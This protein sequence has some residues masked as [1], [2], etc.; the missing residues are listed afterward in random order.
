MTFNHFV[1]RLHLYLALF[2][3][4]WFFVY[5]V[6]SWVFSHSKWF[7]HFYEDG[8]PMWTVRFEKPYQIDIPK[9]GELRTIGG[10]IVHD[11][12]LDG[13]Y[14]AY[15]PPGSRRLEVFLYTFWHSARLTYFEDEHRL[16]VEDRRFRWDQFLTG[17]H[18]RGGF[19]QD[20]LLPKLWGAFVDV[21]SVGILL[22]IATGL[23]MWWKL[24]LVRGWGWLALVAGT[25]SFALFLWKL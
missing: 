19:E 4:P 7:G 11:A 2:V 20:G 15:R 17:M 5:G 24:P 23:Y 10:K 9:E 12:G 25:V 16:R 6:S 22:W 1:R 3:L 21:A 13:L 18:A 14:G 8:K